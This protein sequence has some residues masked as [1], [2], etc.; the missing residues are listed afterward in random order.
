MHEQYEELE[1]EANLLVRQFEEM[2]NNDF[3]DRKIISNLQETFDAEISLNIESIHRLYGEVK[4]LLPEVVKRRFEEV[5]SFHESIVQNR[6]RYLRS[7]I[8]EAQERIA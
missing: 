1:Q 7:E 2:S 6:R 5:R 3:V 8:K 4:L